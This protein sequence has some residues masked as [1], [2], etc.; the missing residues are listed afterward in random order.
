LDNIVVLD[1]RV[2]TFS[3]IP[4]AMMTKDS[5]TCTVD[6]I[7]FM[8]VSDP[9]RAVLEVDQYKLA[10]RNIAATTLRGVIG[11]YD[12]QAVISQRMLIN[13]EIRQ[14]IQRETSS[15]GV[16]VPG[17][18]I[19][20]VRLPSNMQ[21]SMAAA[22]EAERERAAKVISAEGEALAAAKLAEAANIISDSPGA[23]QLRYLHTLVK[24]SAEKNST[25]LFP[26]PMEV[27]RGIKTFGD[28]MEQQVMSNKMAMQEKLKQGNLNL[29][30]IQ[31]E[32]QQ[33]QSANSNP[34]LG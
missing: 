10:F 14:I 34:M 8:K 19:R 33:Q 22:S 23:L 31:E 21:R 2:T 30:D 11:T 6:A 7:V 17:V 18:E 13:E 27:M 20:D 3:L 9:I 1:L 32:E 15:W 24:V 28:M 12:L 26:L 4:Q 5:V 16:K 25:I 29:G